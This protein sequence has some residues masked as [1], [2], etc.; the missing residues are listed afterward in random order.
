[1]GK[2]SRILSR[3]RVSGSVRLDAATRHPQ[4]ELS[5][6][7]TSVRESVRLVGLPCTPKVAPAIH[8]TGNKLKARALFDS[9]VSSPIIVFTTPM[10]PSRNP[11][12]HRPKITQPN[13]V[14]RPKVRSEAARPNWP[15]KMT[16]RRPIRSDSRPHCSAVRPVQHSE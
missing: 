2:L 12:R 1:M 5:S 8:V 11:A 10:F 16:G 6:R 14:E 7:L 4:A 15:R 3:R 13:R 9:S